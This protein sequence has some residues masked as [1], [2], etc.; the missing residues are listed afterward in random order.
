MAEST[1]SVPTHPVAPRLKNGL[2]TPH[3]GPDIDAYRAAHA[4]TVAGDSDEWWEKVCST[5]NLS[6]SGTNI[7][8][9]RLREKPCTGI[10][11][12]KMSEPEDSERGTSSG[13]RRGG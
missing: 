8:V 3:I 13:S 9:L 7:A 2:K 12:S 6:L 4:V 5:G 1:E 11:L 10:V